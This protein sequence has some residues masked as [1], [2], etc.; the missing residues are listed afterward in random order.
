MANDDEAHVIRMLKRFGGKTKYSKPDIAYKVAAFWNDRN[1]KDVM[2]GMNVQQF[3]DWAEAQDPVVEMSGSII[4]P[5][6]VSIMLRGMGNAFGLD[7]R[8]SKW[9][10]PMARQVLKENGIAYAPKKSRAEDWDK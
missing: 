8:M 6:R 2:N 10:E 9:W 4:M 1:T 7:M 5:A 3:L